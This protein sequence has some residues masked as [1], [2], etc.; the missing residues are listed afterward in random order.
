[1]L[2]KYSSDDEVFRP[3]PATATV[4]LYWYRE[5]MVLAT[6]PGM[7][8]FTWDVHYQP[9]DGTNRVGG[10]NLPI[11][12]IGHDTVPN[13]TTPWANPG[14]Y[15]VRLTVSG[16]SYTQPITVKQDPRVTTP[17]AML[18]QVYTL[19][20]AAYDGAVAARVA[21][22]QSR[23]GRWWPDR[24]CRS[25][26]RARWSDR[27]NARDCECGPG[28]RDESAA[29]SRRAPH[30][31]ATKRHRNRTRPGHARDGTVDDGVHH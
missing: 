29:E 30:D 31:R 3:D 25:R 4:P 13:P 27:R 10:P 24:W 15:T 19:S 28:R 17:A 2:R 7:H 20:R 5:P 18:Q 16:K 8:R 12:A 11:A 1:V 23:A 6:T 21:G 22:D 14:R 26:R 9:V